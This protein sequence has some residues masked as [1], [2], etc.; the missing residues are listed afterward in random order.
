MTN[1]LLCGDPTD[2]SITDA[3]IPALATYGGV[4]YFRSGVAEQY[5]ENGHFC[6]LESVEVPKITLPRGIL[7]LKDKLSAT[8]CAEVPDNFVCVIGSGNKQ[9]AQMLCRSKA[10]VVTCGTG[11][12]DTLSLA[13]IDSSSACVSLQRNL[14]TLQG[15]LI[16]PLDFSVNLSQQRTPQQI[17]F[18]SAVLLL[19]GVD[20]EQGYSI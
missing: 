18:V 5:G 13:G 10:A 16:E 15:N 12:T 20:V 3:L 4:C 11:M 17:L 8:A 19:A 2:T 9:A 7:V 14:I 1:V 6:L